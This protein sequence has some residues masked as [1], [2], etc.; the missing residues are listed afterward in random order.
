MVTIPMSTA[1]RLGLAV[2]ERNPQRRVFTAG[3]VKYAP[4]V[5]LSS[6]TVEGWEINNVKALVLDLPDQSELGLLG[7]NYLRRFHMVI[8]TERGTLLL[9]PR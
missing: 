2:D 8:N 7:L 6:I 1:E 3:G 9:E 5:N 4:E